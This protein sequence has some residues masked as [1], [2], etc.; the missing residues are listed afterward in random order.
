MPWCCPSAEM[1]ITASTCACHLLPLLGKFALN[2]WVCDAHFWNPPCYPSPEKA[3]FWDLKF[4]SKGKKKRTFKWPQ[5][6]ASSWA[7]WTGSDSSNK[8][9]CVNPPGCFISML[10]LPR[11]GWWA[12]AGQKGPQEYLSGLFSAEKTLSK[13]P[14]HKVLTLPEKQVLL[15]KEI[16]TKCVVKGDVSAHK[17][18]FLEVSSSPLSQIQI[19]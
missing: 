7:C 5:N 1:C 15:G 11:W 9:L 10:P 17:L 6:C 3:L 13:V 12:C 2:L 16:H 19:T 4:V 8:P 14:C 18:K